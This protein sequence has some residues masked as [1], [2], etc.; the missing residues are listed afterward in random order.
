MTIANPNQLLISTMRYAIVL[1]F[2]LIA[3]ASAAFAQEPC[4]PPRAEITWNGAA[5]TTTD[6]FD[7]YQWYLNGEVIDG[8]T[9]REHTPAESGDYQVVVSRR[10][11]P[12]EFI[13]TSRAEGRSSDFRL[14]PNPASGKVYLQLADGPEGSV[15][16]VDIQGRQVLQQS[17]APGKQDVELN[18][19]GLTTGVYYLQ[20]ERGNR[21]LVETLRV[22]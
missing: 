19:Q 16:V 2:A 6:S 5:L 14:Y 18:I 15:R 9:A 22:E 11:S 7:S 12:F 13:P 21:R 4:E 3:T 8:A 17:I 20:L 1:F 10:S